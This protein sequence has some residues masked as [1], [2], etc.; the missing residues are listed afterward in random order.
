MKI[1]DIYLNKKVP[2]VSIVFALCCILLTVLSGIFMPD[3]IIF[4]F[5]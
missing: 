2:V 5:N 3:S 4:K 1:R